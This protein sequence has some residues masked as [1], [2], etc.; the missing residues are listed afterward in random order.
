MVWNYLHS[1]L[2]LEELFLCLLQNYNFTFFPFNIPHFL[3]TSI[4]SVENSNVIFLFLFLLLVWRNYVFLPHQSPLTPEWVWKFFLILRIVSINCLDR[5]PLVFI[6]F[7]IFITSWICR[8]ESLI[9]WKILAILPLNIF[10]V[11]FTPLGILVIWFYLFV[12]LQPFDRMLTIYM[13]SF[14]S[15]A[16]LFC[17]KI[18]YST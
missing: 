9:F 1:I 6:L 13:I 12:C 14:S 2:T 3:M 8:L 11:L 5:I 18:F 4:F 16:I 7:S 17:L 10:S 15:G